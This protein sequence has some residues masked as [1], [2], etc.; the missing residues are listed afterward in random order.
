MKVVIMIEKEVEL[1]T[2]LVDVEPRYWEDSTVNGVED[3]EGGLI[4]CRNGENW[5]LTIDIESGIIENWEKGI[6]AK[7]HYKVCD[8]GFYKLLDDEGNCVLEKYGYVPK[9]LDLYDDSY[10]DYIIL[11]IGGDGKISNWNSNPNID[12]FTDKD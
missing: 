2:L 7:I 1:K 8:A 3:T 12:D 5:Q 9:I 6:T 11:D 4:P 10:G